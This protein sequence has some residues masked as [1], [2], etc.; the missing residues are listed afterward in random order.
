[1]LVVSFFVVWVRLCRDLSRVTG[2]L[3]SGCYLDQVHDVS[4]QLVS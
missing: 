3:I 2:T 1:M 4:C